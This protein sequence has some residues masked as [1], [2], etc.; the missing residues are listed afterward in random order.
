MKTDLT[1]LEPS[2]IAADLNELLTVTEVAELLKVSKSWVYEHTRARE[3]RHSESLPH[4]RIGKYLRFEA[5]AVRLFLARRA[6][7]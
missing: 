2:N 3:M 4:I 1:T 6:H 5:Q 7:D